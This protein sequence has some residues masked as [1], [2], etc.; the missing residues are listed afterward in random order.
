MRK[1]FQVFLIVMIVSSLSYAADF[2]PTL[3]KL[4]AEP[5]IQYDFD[6]SELT[7]PLQVSGTTAGVIFT[8]FTREMAENIPDAINGY[9]GW[10][11]VNKIDTCIYYSTLKNMGVGANTVTWDGKDQDGGV[12]PAGE[13]TYY[14]WAYDNQGSKNKM[15]DFNTRSGHN[16]TAP[17]QIQGIDENGLPMA[18]PLYYEFTVRWTLGSDPMDSLLLETTTIPFAEGWGRSTFN[19]AIDE[20]DF[21]YF[22]V[23]SVNRGTITACVTKYKWVPGGESEFQ[24]DFG[25]GGYSEAMHNYAGGS[26]PGVQTDG[27]YLYTVDRGAYN[28]EPPTDFYIFD[29]DGSMISSVDLQ[30]WWSPPEDREAGGQASGGPNGLWERNSKLFLNCHCSCIKQMVDPL[31]FLDSG[32]AEDFFVWTNLNGDYVFDHNWEDTAALPW[33]CMDYNVGPFVYNL[34]ADD[35]LFSQGPCYD[36]GA[37]SFGLLAPDGT[38]LGY[39]AFAGE[40]AGWKKESYFLDSDTPFDGIYCDNEHAGSGSAMWEWEANEFTQG[41]YFIGH[42]SITGVITSGVGVAEEAPTAF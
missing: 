15:F 22:F 36:S 6:G 3:L 9:I 41:I 7:I 23:K 5:I 42:D 26:S 33:V 39:F 17:M 20:N 34:D 32:D 12:V 16:N 10:H 8:V 35:K 30:K 31:R 38:G 24:S 37:V 25:D 1:V 28:T 27:T 40:T 4:S 21:N 14:L 11:Q 18:N 2:A 19:P 13:Y 29:L